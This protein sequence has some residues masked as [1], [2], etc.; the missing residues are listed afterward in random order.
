MPRIVQPSGHHRSPIGEGHR[1]RR[2]G[3]H[4]EGDEVPHGSCERVAPPAFI[5]TFPVELDYIVEYFRPAMR[6][7]AV[8]EADESSD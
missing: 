6:A 2:C 3:P 8:E 5:A 4:A 7:A 1:C